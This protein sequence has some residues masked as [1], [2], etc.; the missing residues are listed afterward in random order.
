MSFVAQNANSN[1]G[2]QVDGS[3]FLYHPGVFQGARLFDR[4]GSFGPA[5][6]YLDTAQVLKMWP[7]WIL[8]LGKSSLGTTSKQKQFYILSM[9]PRRKKNLEAPRMKKELEE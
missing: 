8:C 5:P 1:V 7:R 2:P 6:L 4:C 9:Y 3:I